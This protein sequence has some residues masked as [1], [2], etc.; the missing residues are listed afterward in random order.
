MSYE[1]QKHFNTAL[2]SRFRVS[3][4]PLTADGH[5]TGSSGV[6]A[7]LFC[8]TGSTWYWKYRDMI[9][10]QNELKHR[11]SRNAQRNWFLTAIPAKMNNNPIT[12]LF[13]RA[14]A[15]ALCP[16]ALRWKQSGAK[17]SRSGPPSAWRE[18]S[19]DNCEKKCKRKHLSIPDI[20]ISNIHILYHLASWRLPFST[21]TTIWCV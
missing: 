9:E 15:A 7:S 1:N 11:S 19:T 16:F 12:I 20:K 6:Q 4:I 3:C 5:S 21:I 10:T 8:P 17:Y 13:H 14:S 18:K 2:C